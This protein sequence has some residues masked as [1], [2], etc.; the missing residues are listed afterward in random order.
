MKQY[1]QGLGTPKAC[2][3]IN[4]NKAQVLTVNMRA[5]YHNQRTKTHVY[6]TKKLFLKVSINQTSKV[7]I[8]FNDESHL[9][10]GLMSRQ[11]SIK[12]MDITKAG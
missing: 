4:M 3:H 5:R 12:M 6:K 1:A 10:D 8:F 11:L 2:Q 7:Q 9:H